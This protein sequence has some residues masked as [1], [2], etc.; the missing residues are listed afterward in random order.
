M[1]RYTI[2]IDKNYSRKWKRSYLILR[3]G[4][5]CYKML[6]KLENPW[7]KAFLFLVCICK[8]NRNTYLYLKT[9]WLNFCLCFW[10]LLFNLHKIKLEPDQ[11]AWKKTWNRNPVKSHEIVLEKYVNALCN[12]SGQGLLFCEE[13][14]NC[15]FMTFLGIFLI[16]GAY[17]S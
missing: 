5:F 16:S 4:D 8:L 15:Y 2:L 10:K 6:L 7:N 3:K 17:W 9:S 11:I 12:R 14:Q 13:F 1:T